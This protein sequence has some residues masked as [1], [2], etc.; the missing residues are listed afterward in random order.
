MCTLVLKVICVSTD[1]FVCYYKKKIKG[2][3]EATTICMVKYMHQ[4]K[5]KRRNILALLQK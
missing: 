4:Y 3:F 5:Q 2:L 1:F